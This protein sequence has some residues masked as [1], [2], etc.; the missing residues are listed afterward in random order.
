M[1]VGVLLLAGGLAAVHLFAGKIRFLRVVPRSRWLSMAG[2]VSLAYVFVHLLPE[3]TERQAAIAAETD[4]AHPLVAAGGE[5]LLFIV[6]LVGFAAFY[7]LEQI[8]SHSRRESTVGTVGGDAETET[9]ASVFWL[10]IGSFSVYNALIGY[11]LLHREE[12]GLWSLLFYFVAMAL[13]FTVNDYGLHDHH[14]EA[15]RRV[16]RWILAAAVLVGFA[17]GYFVGVP[18]AVLS[19]LLAFIAGGVILNVI[20]EE[21]PD[22]RQS[23][24]WAFAAGVSV[25]GGLLLLV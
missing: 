1:V 9:S 24:F 21:L 4:P 2:G 20:K 18:E 8:A 15:Y 11:L 25:Y 22:D 3:I 16:G 6:A 23:R 7:G 13:H 19:L 10:H 17:V 12:M 14:R 5:R